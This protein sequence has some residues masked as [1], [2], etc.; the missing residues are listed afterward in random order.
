MSNI[1][2]ATA[3]ARR[4]VRRILGCGLGHAAWIVEQGLTPEP[5]PNEHRRE[6]RARLASDL[7]ERALDRQEAS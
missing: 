7:R 4:R 6:V 3:E 1:D 5:V 2:H